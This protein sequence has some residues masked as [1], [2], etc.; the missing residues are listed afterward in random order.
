[1]GSIVMEA[2]VNKKP[3]KTT[4]AKL[5]VKKYRET[6]R[7]PENINYYS[8]EDYQRAEKKYLRFCLTTGM[9]EVRREICTANWLDKRISP[10]GS[11]G[12]YYRCS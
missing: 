12:M 3:L 11:D 6:F 2:I 10:S 5:L 7:I 8:K 1:M 4:G 9:C